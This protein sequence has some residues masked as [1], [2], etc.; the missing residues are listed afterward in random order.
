MKTILLEV[1]AG[2]LLDRFS[3]LEIKARR[4]QSEPQGSRIRRELGDV[5]R[6][7][8][9]AGLLAS[10]FE[11]VLTELRDVNSALWEIE[12]DIRDCDTRHDFGARFIDL[13][14][15]V[16]TTND[17]RSRLKRQI[18]DRFGSGVGEEKVYSRR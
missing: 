4:A 12:D 14:R 1:G 9:G 5:R 18:D 16:Y 13:A 2:E 7:V 3:I 11:S 17:R 15:A 10:D 8:E 6:A